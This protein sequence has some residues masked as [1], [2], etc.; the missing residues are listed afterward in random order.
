MT[1]D[2]NGLG[3]LN[4]SDNLNDGIYKVELSSHDKLYDYSA[5]AIIKV[6]K[7]LAFIYANDFKTIYNSGKYFTVELRD[8]ENYFK[9]INDVKLALKVNGK[10]YYATTNKNGKAKFN[11]SKWKAGN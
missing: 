4:L 1:I 6:N 3:V 2:G 5:N 11:V 9:S 10:T 8:D 7:V